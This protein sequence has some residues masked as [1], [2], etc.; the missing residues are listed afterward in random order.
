MSSTPEADPRPDTASSPEPE[1]AGE[2][3]PA[4]TTLGE[5]LD[6]S[7]VVT[8][9]VCLVVGLAVAVLGTAT[10]RASVPWGLA[11]ALLAAACAAVLARALA[12]GVGLAVYGAAVLLVT[13]LMSQ[14]RPGGDVVIA[15]DLLGYAWLFGPLV[16]C[17]VVAF[18]PARWFS[19]GPQEPA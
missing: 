13:Q 18:L 14:L 17:A 19:R 6:A 9:P 16:A 10:H 12:G 7:R 1:A 8:V 2:A 11:L 4:R 5:V 15:S 3:L